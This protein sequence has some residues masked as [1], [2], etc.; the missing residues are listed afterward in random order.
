MYSQPRFSNLRIRTNNGLQ[1]SSGARILEGTPAS[2]TKAATK[3]LQ[4]L[5]V[6]IKLETKISGSA[7]RPD[8]KTELTL[9]DGQKITTDLYLPT[10]G[11]LP[12]SSYI[13][14]A[15]LNANGFVVVD[16]FLRAKGTTDVWAVGDI[17]SVLRPQF[18]NTEKQSVH[19][20]KN[21]GL[22]MKGKP[23]AKFPVDEKGMFKNHLKRTPLLILK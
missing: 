21:I 7:T 12:N 10:V 5:K 18:V 4:E 9:S 20:A 11:L 2:V 1:I 13:P 8:G 16:E 14:Q 15:L 6:N 23:L 22:L 19:V 17:S 3:K